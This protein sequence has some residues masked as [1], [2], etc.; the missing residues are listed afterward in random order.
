MG[1]A[2]TPSTDTL[3]A[4]LLEPEPM[5]MPGMP[6]ELFELADVVVV[7]GTVR[8][9]S[10]LAQ[11]ASRIA[12]AIDRRG[13]PSR[14]AESMASKHRGASLVD[15][16]FPAIG[17]RQVDG[18]LITVVNRISWSVPAQPATAISRGFGLPRAALGAGC[19]YGTSAY[20]A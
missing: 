13:T 17:S 5:F 4:L 14:S 18:T 2:L 8:F 15:G 7:E 10:A 1:T 16:G 12:N 9:F 6:L 3:P 20:I 19:S 11:P